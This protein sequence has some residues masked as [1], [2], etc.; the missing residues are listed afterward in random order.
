MAFCARSRR[1]ALCEIFFESLERTRHRYEM[2]VY[3]YVVMPEHVHLLVSEPK[4]DVLATVIQSLKVSL[5]RRS[6]KLRLE[7]TF[8]QKR[9]YDHNIREG[10]SFGEKLSYIPWNPVRR[11]LCAAPIDWKWSSFRR[12]AT[13]ELGPVEVESEW[14]MRRREGREPQL[15]GVHVGQL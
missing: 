3:G 1:A 11:G 9:Y 6:E 8:W 5:V 15:L 4:I 14:T 12:Y 2:R 10:N 7:G 13:G